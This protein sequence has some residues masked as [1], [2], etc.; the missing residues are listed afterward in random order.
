MTA[1]IQANEIKGNGSIWITEKIGIFNFS[2]STS[3][4][5]LDHDDDKFQYTRV[6]HTI[7]SINKQ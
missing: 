7:T 5:H 1:Y 6:L 4:A 2:L 3:V